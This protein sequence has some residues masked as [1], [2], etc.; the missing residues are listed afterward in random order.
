MYLVICK[1]VSD[2]YWELQYTC[3]LGI[4][5]IATVGETK[6]IRTN[7]IHY[8][9]IYFLNAKEN[10]GGVVDVW[11]VKV[12]AAYALID[13][14]Q[15]YRTSEEGLL[16]KEVMASKNISTNG[17]H[18]LLLSILSSA[19]AKLPQKFVC[20][21]I[22]VLYKY[23]CVNKAEKFSEIESK[24]SYRKDYSSLAAR[25]ASIRGESHVT[26]TD[27]S[28][29]QGKKVRDTQAPDKQIANRIVHPDLDFK[30]ALKPSHKNF[31]KHSKVYFKALDTAIEL[32]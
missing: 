1:S 21:N 22:S 9:L 27:H 2:L 7:A 5:M 20:R 15:Q 4:G 10:I 16:A 17:E 8:G 29:K 28:S 30:L 6:H 14:Y 19:S 3:V 32:Q 12:A 24:N 13:V 26:C 31:K 25:K 18:P 11:K 23:T